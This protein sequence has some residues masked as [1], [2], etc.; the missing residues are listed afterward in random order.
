MLTAAFGAGAVNAKLWVLTTTDCV[1]CRPSVVAV[2]VSVPPLLAVSVKV[3]WR[4]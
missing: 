1:A 3:F 2:I 4:R